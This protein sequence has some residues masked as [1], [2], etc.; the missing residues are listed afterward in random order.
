[1]AAMARGAG[2]L[3]SGDW[4]MAG[5]GGGVGGFFF[6]GWAPA[7]VY[8]VE[9]SRDSREGEAVGVWESPCAS[10]VGGEIT[11]TCGPGDV[12]VAL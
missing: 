6:S 10:A 8:R 3:V 1:V 5:G 12:R 11:E 9:S 2:R 4:P 7:L